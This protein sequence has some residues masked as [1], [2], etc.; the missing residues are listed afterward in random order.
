MHYIL[1]I[2]G[3]ALG[4]T[5]AVSRAHSHGASAWGVLGAALAWGVAGFFF[6]VGPYFSLATV[7][8]PGEPEHLKVYWHNL[9]FW[10]LPGL[11]FTLTG[12]ILMR[13]AQPRG[14]LS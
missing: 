5:Y 2:V 1:A 13:I 4:S 11:F 12:W 3:I 8:E 6:A 9:P 7:I 10:I 14:N